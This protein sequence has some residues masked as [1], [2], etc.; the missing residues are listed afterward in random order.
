MGSN[1]DSVLRAISYFHN[2][3]LEDQAMETTNTQKQSEIRAAQAAYDQTKL[4]AAQEQ[5]AMKILGQ[6]QSDTGAA[7]NMQQIQSTPQQAAPVETPAAPQDYN[8]VLNKLGQTLQGGSAPAQTYT[9]QMPYSPEEAGR[10]GAIAAPKSPI[11]QYRY[12]AQKLGGLAGTAAGQGA[13]EPI[14]KATSMQQAEDYHKDQQALNE[15]MLGQ[16]IGS[17]EHIAEEANKTKE[18]IAAEKLAAAAAKNAPKFNANGEVVLS[19]KQNQW[20]ETNW[21]KLTK[22]AS[23]LNASSRSAVGVAALANMRAD[24]ALRLLDQEHPNVEDIKNLIT[25]DLFGIMNGGVPHAEQLK[26][27]YMGSLG[28]D[29]MGRWQKL[30][31]NPQDYTNKAVLSHIRDVITNL[32][33]VD[34]DIISKNAGVAEASYP[35]LIARHPDW[36]AKSMAAMNSGNN[37]VEPQAASGGSFDAL[38]SKHGGK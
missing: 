27:G 3:P 29:V 36:W 28:A 5:D 7:Q 19:Q 31:G 17:S 37:P 10:L 33:Q 34:N 23:P 35:G 22:L 2:R 8:G 26:E 6:M 38:W 15:R 1:L 9:P 21:P 18:Q 30:T 16:R 24:R 4:K 14:Y 20:D 32:K 11:E 13:L 12:L 25:P